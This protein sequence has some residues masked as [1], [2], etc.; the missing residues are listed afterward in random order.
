EVKTTDTEGTFLEIENKVA[1]MN[2]PV[3]KEWIGAKTDSVEVELYQKSDN[4]LVSKIV[5]NEENNWEGSFENINKYDKNGNEIEYFIKEVSI[6]GYESKIEG[7]QTEGYKII[8]TQIQKVNIDV[9]KTWIGEKKDSVN[10]KLFANG[11][12]TDRILELSDSNNWKGTFNNLVEF[13]ENGEKIEYTIQEVG[14]DGYK[15]VI[16]KVDNKFEITNISEEKI[17]IPVQKNWVGSPEE[18]VT[19]NL[20]KGEEIVDSIK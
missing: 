4:T 9:E 7:N 12:D 5:L 18:E 6:D 3:T 2:I 10:I 8:N 13:N 1:K 16:N 19:I 11:K 15:T 14:V 17:S 20:L